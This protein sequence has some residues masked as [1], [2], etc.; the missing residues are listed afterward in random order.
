MIRTDGRPT[1][2]WSE[3]PNSHPIAYMTTEEGGLIPV[4][5]TPTPTPASP[6]KGG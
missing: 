1:I 6:S 5:D 2:A 3:Q 4:T